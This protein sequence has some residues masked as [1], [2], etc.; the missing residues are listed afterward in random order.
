MMSDKNNSVR[1][2]VYSRVSSQEQATEGT[3]MEFQDGQITGYCTLQNWTIINAYPDP[4]FSGKDGDRPGLERLLSYAKISFFDKVLVFKLDRLARNLRLLLEIEQKLRGY[5][6]SLISVKEAI[7]T[8]SSTGKMMFQLFGMLP[9]VSVRQLFSAR[10]TASCSDLNP[11]AGP[12]AKH[13][14]AM[15]PLE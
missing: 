7:D 9:N 10:Q 12:A 14:L 4:G 5:G 8:S 11:A 3:F 2:G 15:S 13:L 1:V 6:V